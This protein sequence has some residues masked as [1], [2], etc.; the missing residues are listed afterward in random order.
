MVVKNLNVLRRH[1]VFCSYVYLR[2]LS[3]VRTMKNK[4]RKEF[5]REFSFFLE[6]KGRII[7]KVISSDKG[8]LLALDGLKK[9][10]AKIRFNIKKNLNIRYCGLEIE[11]HLVPDDTP[12]SGGMRISNDSRGKSN[13]QLVDGWFLKVTNFRKK[14]RR[15][16]R[17]A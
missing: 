5:Y 14:T 3:K 1:N 15:K 4:K 12:L 17:V 10:K 9:I 2:K 13:Y 8:S 7:Y 6:N 11:A 16:K